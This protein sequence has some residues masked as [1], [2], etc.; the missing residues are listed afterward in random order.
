MK[1]IYLITLIFVS[2]FKEKNN[3]FEIYTFLLISPEFHA[4][5]LF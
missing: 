4:Y 5:N 2:I 3:N 1:F